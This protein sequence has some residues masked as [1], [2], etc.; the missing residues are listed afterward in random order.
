MTEETTVKKL[1]ITKENGSESDVAVTPLEQPEFYHECVS[2][3]AASDFRR[4]NRSVHRNNLLLETKAKDDATPEERMRVK[5]AQSE[6]Y[7]E[8]DDLQIEIEKFLILIIKSIPR[9]WLV[10]VAPKKIEDGEW[11]DWV[12]HDR[13][14]EVGEA[15]ELDTAR[16]REET[17]N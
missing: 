10:P 3:R 6:A 13:F 17:K 7:D 11:L 1:T 2:Y 4:C 15:Y 16:R 8:L 9:S 5:I 14:A 12:R